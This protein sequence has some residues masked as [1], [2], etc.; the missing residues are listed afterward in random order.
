MSRTYCEFFAGIGLV[1]LALDSLGWRC[2]FANDIDP[3]K[4][5]LY[6]QNFPADDLLVG[7]I[8]DL[9]VEDLPTDAELWTASF[10]CVDLSLA[11]NRRGLNG[12]YS[13]A[14]WGFI[15]LLRHAH[16]QGT[17][18]RLILLENVVG[19]LTSA[20]GADLAAALEALSNLD[21]QYDLVVI[22]ARYFAPQSRPR[23][24]VAAEQ[25]SATYPRLQP[26]RPARSDSPLRPA[27]LRKFIDRH[28]YLSWARLGL[29]PLPA[30]GAGLDDIVEHIPADHPS[31]WNAESADKLLSTMSSINQSK[32]AR[33]L[34]SDTRCYGTVYRRVRAGKTVAELRTDG[35]AGCLR[36]PR[37]GSS[38]QF[39]VEVERQS[40]RVRS[41]TVRECARLQGVPE[42]FRLDAPVNQAWYG[43]GD[44]V[45]V[46]AVR[47]LASS[48]SED[49][50]D[51]RQV[52]L[53]L[54]LAFT[55]QYG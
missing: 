17:G 11:G 16:K 31:W 27:L 13:G 49:P 8:F 20:G 28:P 36:T 12:T 50:V 51:E 24:F 46:P 53:E 10:P 38:K 14:Y 32:L 34:R 43:L 1:R 29:P 45:C 18:P 23:L 21:Y 40:V 6:R 48:F 41:L 30:R 55:D 35:I 3:K 22:D 25:R 26:R 42:S 54:D 52:Q 5:E 37:G 44:A 47:W 9:T 2:T 4:A 15:N 39:L 19:L 7:D 33:M